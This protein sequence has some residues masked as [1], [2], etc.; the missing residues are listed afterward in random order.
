MEERNTPAPYRPDLKWCSDDRIFD[1]D[2]VIQETVLWLSRAV[3][4]HYE[5]GRRLVWAKEMLPHGEFGDWVQEKLGISERT[6]QRFMTV[7]T[8][9]HKHPSALNLLQHA[10]PHQ[11]LALSKQADDVVTDILNGRIAGLEPDTIVESN[12]PELK[13]KLADLEKKLKAKEEEA[14]SANAIATQTKERLEAIKTKT[15]SLSQQLMDA[16]TVKWTTDEAQLLA[17][18]D[19][20]AQGANNLFHEITVVLKAAMGRVKNG[21]LKNDEAA[22]CI[23][24]KCVAVASHIATLGQLEE[25]DVRASAG[26][27]IPGETV[28]KLFAL[29][30]LLPPQ[31]MQR[32]PDTDPLPPRAPVPASLV[33][34]LE[35]RIRNAKEGGAS[36][37]AKLFVTIADLEALLQD[38]PTV[39]M[40]P[41][42]EEEEADWGD[43]VPKDHGTPNLRVVTPEPRDDRW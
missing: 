30:N 11:I 7:A 42:V 35:I 36:P 17:H 28:D 22:K 27:F 12:E 34:R 13:R 18:L 3:V 23:V 20:Q 31:I 25:M 38:V 15:D 19:R 8:F 10:K 1:E 14:E 16:T 37:D 6:S 43:Q 4:A 26:E 41:D 32:A 40:G 33:E 9:F 24:A 5:I 29:Y 2:V 21:E 39:D